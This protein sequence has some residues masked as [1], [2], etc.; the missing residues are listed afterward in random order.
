[1][2]KQR[3]VGVR[4]YV[5]EHDLAHWEI[6]RRDNGDVIARVR[7]APKPDCVGRTQLSNVLTDL[8]ALNK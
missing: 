3:I 4:L 6:Y 8:E 5:D 2:S 7:A 1:M